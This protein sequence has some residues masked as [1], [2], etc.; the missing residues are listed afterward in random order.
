MPEEN[1][2]VRA[3]AWGS[4]MDRFVLRNPVAEID[5]VLVDVAAFQAPAGCEMCGHCCLDGT[6]VPR[7]VGER[8]APHV[9]EIAGRYLPADR[10]DKAGW[11]FSPAW[12]CDM[13]NIVTIAPGKKGCAFLFEKEGR[14]LCSIHAWSLDTGR[15][16]L[17]FLPFECFMFPVAIVPYDGILHPGKRLLTIF[18]A[19]TSRI[20]DLYGPG[21]SMRHSLLRRLAFDLGRW[22]KRKS[23][24]RRWRPARD[25]ECYFR[26]TPGVHKAPGYEYFRGAVSWNFGTEFYEKFVEAVRS[27]GAR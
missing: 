20:V 5:G 26:N 23:P 1:I 9:A 14:S 11:R 22:M 18:T 12:D 17:D 15:N 24:W 3:E 8:L 19:R 27:D 7:E 21:R 16:P 10:R 25:E 4:D 13:T 2:Q 6:T